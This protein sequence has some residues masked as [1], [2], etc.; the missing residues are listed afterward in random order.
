MDKTSTPE[1]PQRIA[2]KPLGVCHSCVFNLFTGAVSKTFYPFFF[3]LHILPFN[4]F[5]SRYQFKNNT[6]SSCRKIYTIKGTVFVKQYIHISKMN[7]IQTNDVLKNLFS[8]EIFSPLLLK[9]WRFQSLCTDLFTGRVYRVQSFILSY[10][11]EQDICPLSDNKKGT[12][13]IDW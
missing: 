11:S 5:K 12:I 9:V 8:P 7:C 3:F 4:M 2:L 1:L 10:P 13:L 6:N